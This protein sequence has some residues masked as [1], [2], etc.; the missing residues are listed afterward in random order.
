MAA[1]DK[2]LKLKGEQ[3]SFL[4]ELQS[5]EPMKVLT[6]Y[7]P[8]YAYPIQVDDAEVCARCNGVALG[9]HVRRG[10]GICV[11]LGFRPRDDQ[12][13]S[14]GADISTLFD[15]LKA[16]GAY[17][18]DSLELI[19][20]PANARY[21]AN[22]FP[23]GAVTLAN[24]Y[25]TF[26]EAWSGPFYRD[27]EEDRLALEG[28]VLPPVG[29][30]LDRSILA[31]H[32][33]TYEG[34]DSLAYLYRKGRLLGFSGHGTQGITID[35]HAWRFADKKADVAFACVEKERLAAGI[36]EAMLVRCDKTGRLNIPCPFEPSEAACCNLDFYC[37]DL[38]A[39]FNWANGEAEIEIAEETAGKWIALV[40]R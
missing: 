30:A 23:N 2:P 12:S 18:Q 3:V 37:A 21:I 7:L 17:A 4:G 31:G 34:T 26:F 14:T 8:D 22:V 24:H 27:E 15:V 13:Q 38:P 39:A 6:D 35:G 36:K 29:I 28:R 10:K 33:V 19:S 11:Y 5:V 16:V 25:R 40:R 9:S 20:R 32:S 1:P